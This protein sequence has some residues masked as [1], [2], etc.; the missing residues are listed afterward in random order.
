M[1]VCV[2][3]A[4]TIPFCLAHDP[5][6]ALTSLLLL[7]RPPPPQVKGLEFNTFSPNLLA[8]GAADR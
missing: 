8:S 4:V 1:L 6:L 5:C 2:T 3:F 7:L